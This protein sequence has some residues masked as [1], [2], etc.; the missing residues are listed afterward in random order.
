MIIGVGLDLVDSNRFLGWT[1]FKKQRI[2]TQAE[3]DYADNTENPEKH[4]ANFWAV[5]EAF[6]KALKTGFDED[7][8]F[9]DVSVTH[10]E[11][12]SPEVLVLGEAKNKLID[13]AGKNHVLHLSISDQGDYSAAIVII[14]KLD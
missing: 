10:N 4:L 11:N 13:L 2:F 5:R 3:L 6:L 7:I 14:E 1:S 12:G 8:T 9:S